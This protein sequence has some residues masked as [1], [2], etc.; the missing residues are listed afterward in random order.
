M[1][2]G[3]LRQ[4]G[5]L[6][7]DKENGE[8]L[9]NTNDPDASN[10]QVTSAKTGEPYKSWDIVFQPESPNPLNGVV[11]LNGIPET[12]GDYSYNIQL[13]EIGSVKFSLTVSKKENETEAP[14]S[15]P[16]YFPITDI[17]IE[18]H[19]FEEFKHNGITIPEVLVVEF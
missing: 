17:K 16:Y 8:N 18:D 15:R 7:V 12:A 9:I 4:V 5:V 13:G 10:I 1:N 14:C 11:R 2:E 3:P 19:P 6:F